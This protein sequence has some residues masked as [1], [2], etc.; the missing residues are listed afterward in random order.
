MSK[1]KQET[2][3]L[4][5]QLPE[6]ANKRPRDVATATW[7]EANLRTGFVELAG[8]FKASANEGGEVAGDNYV[9]REECVG[10]MSFAH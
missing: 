1:Y 2:L 9:G 3:P 7:V 10:N 8:A 5:P 6:V 4:R